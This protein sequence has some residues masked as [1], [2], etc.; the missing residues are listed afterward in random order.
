MKKLFLIAVLGL[1]V[2]ASANTFANSTTN[3]SITPVVQTDD[4][5]EA[6]KTEESEEAS[7]AKKCE[8]KCDKSCEKKCCKKDKSSCKKK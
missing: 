5:P 7:E 4:D 6:T 2:F 8:K 3:I 1:F